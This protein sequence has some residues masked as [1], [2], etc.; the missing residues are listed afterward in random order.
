MSASTLSRPVRLL[1]ISGSARTIAGP[2]VSSMQHFEAQHGRIASSA[3][4]TEAD[5]TDATRTRLLS[6]HA[7][8]AAVQQLG[9]AVRPSAT[10]AS[11]ASAV[12]ML[13]GEEGSFEHN[14]AAPWCT[15]RFAW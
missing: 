10:A 11:Y 5:R 12:D 8:F 4:V 13:V 14:D 7:H 1:A 9:E 2:L 15:G 3:V 6:G